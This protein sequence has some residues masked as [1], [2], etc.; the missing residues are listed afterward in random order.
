MKDLEDPREFLEAIIG[1]S[2]ILTYMRKLSFNDFHKLV[3]ALTTAVYEALPRYKGKT[4][5]QCPLCKDIK[6]IVEIEPPK[7][8]EN[9]KDCSDGG[10]RV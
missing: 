6:G 4:V 9:A 1:H 8:E 10:E 3:S 2:E 7:S 5:I